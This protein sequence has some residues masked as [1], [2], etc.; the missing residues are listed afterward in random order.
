MAQAYDRGGEVICSAY[1]RYHTFD[2]P[3][4]DDGYGRRCACGELQVYRPPSGQVAKF[5]DVLVEAEDLRELLDRY[6]SHAA[7]DE[8]SERLGA[9][10]D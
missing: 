6:L 5:T 1:E 7:G 8:L 4:G 9:L 2:V 3:T 10:I